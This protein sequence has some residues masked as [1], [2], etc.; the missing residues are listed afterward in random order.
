[1]NSVLL[2]GDFYAAWL[3][4]HVETAKVDSPLCRKIL[5]CMI[6]REKL[7]F[8]N[9]A[10]LAGIFMDPRY[11]VLLSDEQI[12]RA[13]IHLGNITFKIHTQMP[14]LVTSNRQNV[15]HIRASRRQ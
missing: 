10:F 4:C 2:T 14:L 6:K 7:L 1:L 15:G 5:E 8:V 13:Y 3:K 9:D 11:K 12:T